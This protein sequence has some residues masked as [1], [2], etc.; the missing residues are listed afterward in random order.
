[1]RP[2]SPIEMMVDQACGRDPNAVPEKAPLEDE[3]KAFMQVVD[4]AKAW[5][6][7]RRP[8][9]FDVD[10]HLRNPTVNTNSAAETALATAV[11]NM[12]V[13]GG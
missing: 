1:M 13:L 11:A 9:D 8:A 5:W 2:R 10:A 6:E 3:T 12:V 7:S 4:T